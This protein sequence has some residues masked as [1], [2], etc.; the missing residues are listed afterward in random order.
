[1][2]AGDPPVTPDLTATTD[3]AEAAR[4]ALSRFTN[5]EYGA[6]EG[7]TR[8]NS[9]SNV[10]GTVFEKLND[11][12]NDITQGL[13]GSGEEASRAA[14]RFG[15][16]STS[17]L[18][19]RRALE[20]ISGIES[21]GLT[22][23]NSQIDTLLQNLQQSPA[24]QTAGS[25]INALKNALT[26]AG[27]PMGVVN[28]VASKGIN[29]LKSYANSFFTSADN[30]LKL[31]NATLQLAART[32]NLD[33][34]FKAAGDSLENMNSL[35]S[36]Q[37]MAMADT[38]KATGISEDAVEKFYM[39]L[40][41]VP[42]ALESTVS[43]G[44]S[45][46]GSMSMLTATI[47]LAHGTGRDF[48]EVVQDLHTSFRDYGLVGE[49]ALKFTARFSELSNK[50]G[51]ELKDMREGLM[52]AAGAFKNIADAIGGAATMTEAAAKIMNDYIGGLKQSGMTGAHAI[53]T[54]RGM[55]D[56]MAGMRIEQKAFLSAQTGG[57][58]GLMGGYQIEKMMRE[59]KIDEVFDK[60]R[61]TMQKQFGKI[62]TLDDASK[63]ETSA[64]QLTKQTMLLRQGP[65]GQIVKSDQDAYRLLET[66]KAKQEGRAPTG[67]IAQGLEPGG[68]QD[69]IKKGSTVEEKSYTTL[70]SINNHMAALRK[71]AE[72]ANLGTAQRAF[73]ASA[74]TAAFAPSEAEI[75]KGE[76]LKGAM[77]KGQASSGSRIKDYADAISSGK[78]MPDM[79]GDMI[80][81]TMTDLQEWFGNLPEMVKAPLE[82]LKSVILSGDDKK[83]QDEAK[84]LEADI[85][86]RKEEIKKLKGDEKKK[87]QEILDQEV[88]KAGA[89]YAWAVKTGAIKREEADTSTGVSAGAAKPGAPAKTKFKLPAYSSLDVAAFGAPVTPGA[90]LAAAPKGAKPGVGAASGGSGITPT[91]N[92]TVDGASGRIK[93]D[94][95]VKV[96]E[97]GQGASI[98]PAPGPS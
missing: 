65:L 37:T 2:A 66:F 36:S 67:G 53:E 83:I 70:T 16:L 14:A 9:L 29:A 21:T 46:S 50:F 79:A 77:A 56:A 32:G 30:A 38:M 81:E 1:M 71:A 63:S 72:A 55:T 68:L 42:K 27:A 20:G 60:V 84:A 89:L 26:S 18:G 25:M 78:M 75:K 49:S 86:R 45:A 85:N 88:K 74:G 95:S 54:I 92:T 39:T 97:M 44:D 90:T 96:N 24:L 87:K 31:Q 61:Q 98:N 15:I 41:Q 80:K 47:K 69:A 33:N 34:V 91:V 22:T 51:V 17:V 23:F 93:V 94:V 12:I 58:G 11:S 13:D 8:L 5:A 82:T 43:S 76:T 6:A 73:A 52:G 7:L 28:D 4:E 19:S 35:L 57:P 59:G 62:V 48:N 40:G 10:L 64:A 3:Q